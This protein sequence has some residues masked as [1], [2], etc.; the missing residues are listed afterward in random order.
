MPKVNDKLLDRGEIFPRL[1]MNKVGGGKIILPD[2]FSG[3]WGVVIF[4]SG[5]W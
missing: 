1:E 5:Y 3:E 2:D 4:Y